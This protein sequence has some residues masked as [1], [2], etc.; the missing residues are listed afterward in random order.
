[1]KALLAICALGLAVV[2]E[3]S[4]DDLG[5]LRNYYHDCPASR[6]PH[7]A[8]LRRVIHRALSGDHPAMRLVIMHEGIFSTGDNE[9]Y[10]EVPQALLR[11]LGDARYAAFVTRQ[12]RHVQT[13]ALS[14]F[15]DQISA[16]ERRC[17]KTAKVYHERFSR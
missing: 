7:A 1:V 13:A 16:F 11:T 12:S 4:S 2:A 6:G 15:P 3:A 10:S 5:L 14:L 9:G 17:P 8:E